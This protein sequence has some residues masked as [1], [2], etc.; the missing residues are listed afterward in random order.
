MPKKIAISGTR[1]KDYFNRYGDLK[2]VQRL[3]FWPL[4]RVLVERYGFT[5][6]DAKGLADFLRPILDF[7]PENRP[8]AESA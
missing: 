1:S 8:T 6:P 3:R 4:E 2:R 5:E 7:D